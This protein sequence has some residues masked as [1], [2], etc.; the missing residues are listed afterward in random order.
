MN[1]LVNI[2]LLK[3]KHLVFHF[4]K[5]LF[6]HYN[7]CI[8]TNIQ[9]NYPLWSV[10]ILMQSDLLY[11]N[12]ENSPI[13]DIDNENNFINIAHESHAYDNIKEA[14]LE[15]KTISHNVLDFGDTN[16]FN[17]KLIE[18]SKSHEF[19]RESSHSKVMQNLIFKFMM[20]MMLPYKIYPL[21]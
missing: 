6:T 9:V 17:Y 12:E 13:Q 16:L 10:P 18:S 5:E 21:L 19:Q 11:K 7:S 4:W 2:V 1:H 15:D 20:M 3:A 8:D 14:N